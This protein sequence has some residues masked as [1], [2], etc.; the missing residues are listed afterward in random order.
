M[1]YIDF[2]SRISFYEFTQD[3]FRPPHF[4]TSEYKDEIRLLLREINVE[5]LVNALATNPKVID[6]L[7]EAF[8]LKR[9][10]NAQY[11][12]FC[13]D[14]ATLNNAS[15]GLLLRHIRKAILKFENGKTNN[16]FLEIYERLL[17]RKAPTEGRHLIFAV[18][19]AIVGY[20]QKCQKKRSVL[21]SHISNSIGSRIRIAKYLIENLS[22]DDYLSGVNLMKFL[23]CKRHPIDTKKLHGDFGIK[24]IAA[25]L[26][27]DGFLNVGNEVAER[28]L[29][30]N[31]LVLGAKYNGKFCYLE[32]KAVHGVT[33]RKAKKDKVFDFVLLYDRR[34]HVLI[35]TNFFTTSGTKIGINQGE[36]ADLLVDIKEFNKKKKFRLGFMWITDGNYWLTKDGETRFDNL[37]KNFFKD[38][39]ELLNY[40]LLRKCLPGIKEEM[41]K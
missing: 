35:E 23:E 28:K 34:V 9:F 38:K 22:A 4:D 27:D 8:Q 41:K 6:V 5:Y 3:E 10:T 40:N 20:V 15:E 36:Y 12:N 37:K 33:K 2:A 31:A 1:R 39:Y 25:I 18:K 29:K 13:F 16:D 32:Q 17:D 26:Q 21:Y 30:P 19:R 24:K 11:I 14:V 7:E